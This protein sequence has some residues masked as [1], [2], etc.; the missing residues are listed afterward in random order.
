M[1]AYIK[2]TL[3]MKATDFVVIDVQGVGYKIFAP[4]TTINQLGEIGTVTKLH[5]HYHV[6]EDNISLYGFATAEELRMFE[7]LISVSGVGAKSANAILAN[8][9]PSKFALSV[10]TNDV[11]ELTKLPGIGAKSAQ[12]I[13]LELKDKLK[14]EQAIDAN[15]ITF[16][17]ANIQVGSG[18]IEEAIAALQV[19]GYPQKEA[20]KAVSTIDTHGLSVEDII[21]KALGYFAK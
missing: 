7:L 4:A 12:R 10:I 17:N 14:T 6:R 8:I 21:K 11:K 13:I 1:F 2:G 16:G 5:T 20:L 15:D 18:N 3:E 19:L 9:T